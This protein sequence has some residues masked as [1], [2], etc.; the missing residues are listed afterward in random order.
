[1]EGSPTF[2][3]LSQLPSG[4]R[5]AADV[6][7]LLRTKVTPG[8]PGTDLSDSQHFAEALQSKSGDVRTTEGL[9]NG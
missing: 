3:D 7:R 8:E 5:R 1:M 9:R 6:L 2:E 4:G